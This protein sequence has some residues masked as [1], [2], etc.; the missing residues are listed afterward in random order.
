M[1]LG[2]DCK[3][4]KSHCTNCGTPTDG[5]SCVAEDRFPSPGDFTICIKCGHLM[6][7]TDELGLR[8]PTDA[9]LVTIAGDDRLILAT[10]ML[11]AITKN[12][13]K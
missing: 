6:C 2:R 9:E 11:G 10:A 3:L 1:L 12:A 4:P 8:E 13:E 5:A 7:F